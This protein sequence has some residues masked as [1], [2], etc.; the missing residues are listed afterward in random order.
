MGF[1]YTKKSRLRSFK[2]DLVFV[3]GSFTSLYQV[4]NFVTILEWFE[5]EGFEYQA[6]IKF[7][8]YWGSVDESIFHALTRRY[9]LRFFLD[10]FD[11]KDFISSLEGSDNVVEVKLNS[12]KM[13]PW[14]SRTV[15]V[16]DE[17]VSVF[18]TS[19]VKMYR[20]WARECRSKNKSPSMSLIRYV[21]FFHFFRF[22]DRIFGGIRFSMVETK[23]G[24]FYE[25]EDFVNCYKAAIGNIGAHLKFEPDS[26]ATIKNPCIIF[27]TAPFELLG[28]IKRS[29]VADFYK[30]VERWC[31]SQGFELLIKPHPADDFRSG[32]F[33]FLKSEVPAEVYFDRLDNISGVIGYNS[34]SLITAKVAYG[35]AAYNI[36]I[37]EASQRKYLDPGVDRVV[38][39]F[40]VPLE[41]IG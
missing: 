5:K 17:G 28:I 11:F 41:L 2:S 25:N 24:K 8:S 1:F 38:K 37:D 33:N 30:R 19:A 18:R 39:N 12:S 4:V 21:T 22:R 7:S 36:V 3:F 40:C 29:D 6:V 14:S 16:V 32:G 35:L 27:L 34:T 9:R 10:V 15:F 31:N 23:L 20:S 13:F 26:Q